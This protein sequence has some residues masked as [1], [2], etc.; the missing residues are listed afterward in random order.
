[1]LNVSNKAARAA[2]RSCIQSG[3]RKR[4]TT[5]RSIPWLTCWRKHS[6]TIRLM[7]LRCT[8]VG[9]TRLLTVTPRR[10][11]PALFGCEWIA[12]QRLERDR[13]L[14]IRVKPSRRVKRKHRGKIR[15]GFDSHAKTYTAFCTS[16]SNHCSPAFSFHA[17][18]KTVSAFSF[19]YGW[20][21]SAFHG[22]F[23]C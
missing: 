6:R 22:L 18:Q 3:F 1:M 4:T 7:L 11:Q 16:S 5:S 12:N 2:A 17:N 21:I 20:L 14:S 15:T 9:I 8:A 19:G 10:A 13:C 23:L